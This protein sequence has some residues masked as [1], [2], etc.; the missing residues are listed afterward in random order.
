LKSTAAIYDLLQDDYDERMMHRIPAAESVT[1]HEFIR[2]ACKGKIVIDIG[3]SG[4]LQQI[5][6]S[7]A[8]GYASVDKE[9]ADY[10]VDL[11]K[12][13][14]PIVDG[15][16]LVVCGEVVEHLSNPGN[17]LDGLRAYTV[18]IIF[19]VPNSMTTAGQR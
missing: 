14:V 11:D 16:E 18:P 5:I 12:Q 6:K 17:F 4:Q 1:R 8:A 9:N 7:V 15:M 10:C 13:P 2:N 19:T 3:G